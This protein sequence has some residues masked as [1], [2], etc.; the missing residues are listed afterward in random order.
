MTSR[1]DS[2]Q[3]E[4]LMS[5]T[6]TV[7]VALDLDELAQWARRH[8]D[9]HHPGI[10]NILYTAHEVLTAGDIDDPNTVVRGAAAAATMRIDTVELLAALPDGAI[11][12][13]PGNH[14]MAGQITQWT[15]GTAF[16][17]RVDWTEGT[18][19]D[20][21]DV[22]LPVY[23]VPRPA[24]LIAALAQP[25]PPECPFSGPSDPCPDCA[26]PARPRGAR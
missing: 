7:S 26:P 20:F 4:T 15:D 9:A 21:A 24:E 6:I 10:A 14:G 25:T 23:Q 8:A 11:I 2:R 13:S 19:Q 18:S 16:E 17:A 3:Q 5:E 12:Y 1:T 22:E